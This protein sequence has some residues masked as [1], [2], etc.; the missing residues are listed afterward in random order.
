MIRVA[1]VD[2]HPLILKIVQQELGRE[3]DM[4]IVWSCVE[5]SEIVTRINTQT[6][7]VLVMD[8]NFAGQGFEPVTT[9]RS[10]LTRFPFMAVLVLT[11]YDAP[12]WIDELVEAG[13]KGY[14]VKSDDF[15]MRLADGVRAVAHGRTF[16]SPSASEGLSNSQQRRKLTPRERT[17]LR[18]AAEGHSNPSI[19]DILGVANGTVRNHISNIYTKLDVDTRDGAIRA[20]RQLRELPTP[21]ASTRHELR[22]PLN[23]IL[24]LARLMEKRLQRGEPI[25]DDTLQAYLHQM[26]AEAERLDGLIE[27]LPG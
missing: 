15:S 3:L 16:L 19:A 21:G 13:V 12:V 14:V 2:D 18:L 17:I 23:T 1:L 26:I 24:G 25:D 11:S 20:A 9:V 5:A 7:D 10:L 27:A 8:L 4:H 22:T 6:P